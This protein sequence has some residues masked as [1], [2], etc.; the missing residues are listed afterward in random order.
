M[1]ILIPEAGATAVPA[2]PAIPEVPAIP[3]VT[4]PAAAAAPVAAVPVVPV[5]PVR[6]AATAKKPKLW[7]ATLRRRWVLIAA[8]LA[9]AAAVIAQRILSRPPPAEPL[10]TEVLS[11]H[12]ISQTVD[13]TGTVQAIEV[14]EI[15]SKASGQILQMPVSIGSVVKAGDLLAQI[16]PLTVRNQYNQLLVARQAAQSSVT[17]T[18][19]QLKRAEELYSREAM[20]AVD[21]EA[22]VLAA[23]NARASLAR[24]SADL[25][26]ARQALND[27]TVRAPSAGTLVEQIATKGMIITSGV[28]AASGGTTL[29]KIADLN[30]IQM[31]ALVG[32]T[33]I[34]GLKPDMPAAVTVDAFPNHRFNGSVI[35]IEP[36]A[37]IQQSVTM[38]PV[39]VAIQNENGQL[40]P[41]MNGEVTFDIA[42]RRQ[43]LAVPLDAVRTTRELNTVA[44]TLGLDADS[45]RA[46][47]QRQRSASAPDTAKAASGA[48]AT[49]ASG[50]RTRGAR[51]AGGAGAGGARAG[52]GAGS[53]VMVQTATGLQPRS[54]RLGINDFDYAEVLSGLTAGEKVVLLSV[55]EQSAKRQ[56]TQKR[57]SQAMGS[58]LSGTS[59]GGNAGRGGH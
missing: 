21:H 46:G 24:A 42:R 31:Q 39:L 29:F 26:I 9:V 37:V 10:A 35:K 30:R 23:A 17:V 34:G 52:G 27:A 20:T 58:A 57:V 41:G 53:F 19:S 7:Y 4:P 56:A 43:V 11:L 5:A 50:R 14:V 48:A 47:L 13:A 33:D 12:D 3:V 40:L 59:S 6:R 18:A 28:S 2:V 49:G 8:V 22:A 32:E 36:Q 38:F 45:L 25:V 1:T 16:D 55:A 54:V 51:G 15:K 44:I